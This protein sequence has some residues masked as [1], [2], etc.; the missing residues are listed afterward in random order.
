MR[1]A[2]PG[3]FIWPG[4][5]RLAAALLLLGPIAG[6]ASAQDRPSL[7]PSRDVDVTYVMAGLD[8]AGQVVTLTQRTRWSAGS[9]EMRVDP[10]GGETYLVI[11]YHA[12]RLYAVHPAQRAVVVMP[13]DP[14][15]VAPG[16]AHTGTFS[17]RGKASVAGLACT[18][19][20]T[21]DSGGQATTVCL[22][23]DGVLLRVRHGDRV[24]AQARSVTFA[25]IHPAVFAVPADFS[26]VTPPG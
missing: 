22:T 18:E 23:A 4:A 1:V 16:M 14:A 9:G 11:D 17:R 15:S 7:I 26:R 2:P 5:T 12:H 13:A 19:W 6:P 25:P 10:P 24:L 8:S 21:Q 3:R 20:D